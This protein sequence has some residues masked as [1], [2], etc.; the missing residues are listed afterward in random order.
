MTLFRRMGEWWLWFL[1]VVTHPSTVLDV[2]A[3][4]WLA[5][6]GWTTVPH[7]GAEISRDQLREAFDYVAK[8]G[9][10]NTVSGR[11]PRAVAR[12]KGMLGA[13]YMF[14]TPDTPRLGPTR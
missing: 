6:R 13:A 11:R 10:L 5:R 3:A 2:L 9:H 14:G 4:R 1:G 7:S 12:L 8:S